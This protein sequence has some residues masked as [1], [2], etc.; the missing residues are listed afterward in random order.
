MEAQNKDDQEGKL[1][2]ELLLGTLDHLR[3]IGTD[4]HIGDQGQGEYDINVDV[5]LAACQNHSSHEG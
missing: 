2:V 1:D 5:N 3:P 4:G